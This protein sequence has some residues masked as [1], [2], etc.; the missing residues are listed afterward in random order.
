MANRD[1]P[2]PSDGETE[3]LTV[4]WRL[5]PSTVRDV[6]R[7]MSREKPIGYTTTLKLMQIMAQKGLVE[8]DV[9]SRT[10]VYRP[11]TSEAGMQEHLVR[12]L[13]QRVFAGSSEKLVM[14]A[15]SAKEVSQ[16]ELKR[17]KKLIRK[18]ERKS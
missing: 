6:N 3:I 17:I 16:A 11:A 18:M 15:L 7:F 13:L 1:I 5:G 2:R 14:R 8:R 4:L 10:H 12:D 9:S